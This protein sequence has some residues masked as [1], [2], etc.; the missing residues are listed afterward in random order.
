[1][2]GKKSSIPN[3][4]AHRHFSF[5]GHDF[6]DLYL[7]AAFAGREVKTVSRSNYRKYSSPPE[8]RVQMIENDFLRWW[9]K[10]LIGAGSA[11]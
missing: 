5:V 11:D 3:D 7:E 4:N 9:A 1:M 8:V 2:I 6:S 10:Q